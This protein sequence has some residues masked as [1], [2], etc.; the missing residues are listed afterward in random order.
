M[1]D[2][3]S[4]HQSPAIT[5][6]IDSIYGTPTLTPPDVLP[7]VA[8]ATAGTPPADQILDKYIQA[9]GGAD[10]L[11]KLTSYTAK[12][13]SH[14]FG[15]VNADPAEIYAK[16]PNQLATLVHQREGDLARTFDGRD[17]WVMLPLTV[18]GEYPLNASAL[19]GAKLDANGVSGR[20]QAIL[21]HL[22]RQLSGH[23][24]RPRCLR[25]SG[26]TA[27]TVCSPHFTSTSRPA[28]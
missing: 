15:E 11:A 5:P 2:L 14:L 27:P 9:L 21:Q 20:A 18:V 7:A 28:C 12:G 3:P 13:T 10:Q 19:E 25:R 4:R 22:A 26:D 8:P 23:S 17:A 24:G 1:L 16:A 6:P